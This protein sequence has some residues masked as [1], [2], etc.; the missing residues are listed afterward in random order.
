M[1]DTPI[2]LI[3]RVRENI[4][5]VITGQERN[6]ELL[7]CAMVCGGHVLMEDVPGVGK[8]TL[9]TALAKSLGC[10]FGRIQFTP[11]VLPSDV[12]GFTLYDLHS[13]EKRL[14]TGAVMNQVVLADEINRTTPKTQSSL[15]EAMQEGQVT[16]DGETH[17]CPAPFFVLATQ[18]PLELTGTYPLPEAQL[19]RFLMRLSMGYPA[20]EEELRILDAHRGK[21]PVKELEPVANAQEILDLQQAAQE[22]ACAPAEA[23]YIVRIAAATRS[24]ERVRLGVSPRGS[25]ALMKAGMAWA[26]MQGRNYVIPDDIQA[27]AVPVLA[28]RIQLN[29]RAQDERD[30]EAGI[31]EKII[32]S[33]AVPQVS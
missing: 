22:I 19:D 18:N 10:S 17:P 26:L 7:L 27:L 30:S 8:T 15:L 20:M 32:S 13:G 12:T 24:S 3:E 16:I 25:I 31:V 2:R 33:L 14:V 21:E 6:I 29:R 11:D 9:A 28:H 23:E 5:S 1:K 4:R